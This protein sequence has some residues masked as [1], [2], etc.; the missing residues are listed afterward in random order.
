MRAFVRIREMLATHKDVARRMADLER[1]QRGQGKQIAEIFDQLQK[2][3]EPPKEPKR[4]IGFQAPK[5]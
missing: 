2:L 1:Q 3:I 4:P 5:K